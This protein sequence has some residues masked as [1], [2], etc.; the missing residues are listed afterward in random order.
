MNQP[1]TDF[2]N[3]FD[4][5]RIVK[6]YEK[7]YRGRLAQLVERRFAEREVTGLKTVGL[8]G[9]P[10]ETFSTAVP[11]S[12]D[13]RTARTSPHRDPNSSPIQGNQIFDKEIA[14]VGY[15]KE[16]LEL[17]LGNCSPVNVN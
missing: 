17:E 4:N 8:A 10:Q 1:C 14:Q 12:L 7:H 16:L 5:F 9:N 6:N 11:T 15:L 13:T 3:N 2:L